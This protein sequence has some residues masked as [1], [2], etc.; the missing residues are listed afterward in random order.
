MESKPSLARFTKQGWA[1]P[2]TAGFKSAFVRKQW[3][4]SMFPL[5]YNVVVGYDRRSG[6]D[7]LD[8]P[9]HW[10]LNARAVATLYCIRRQYPDG[11]DDNQRVRGDV[12]EDA[13]LW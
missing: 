1:T 3:E 9:G 11:D 12:V 7:G 13:H 8:K 5:L 2:S 10:M 6:C 4:K